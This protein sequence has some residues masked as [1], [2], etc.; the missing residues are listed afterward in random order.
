MHYI[1]EN[2]LLEEV[3]SQDRVKQLEAQLNEEITARQRLEH[4]YQ[5]RL[6][7]ARQD[8]LASQQRSQRTITG[9]NLNALLADTMT[10][11]SAKSSAELFVVQ[12]AH[13]EIPI[14]YLNRQET[15]ER[16]MAENEVLK[17]QAKDAFASLSKSQSVCLNV[18]CK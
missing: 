17:L 15:A 6:E 18:F 10:E 9:V 16:L 12:V 5:S 4:E 1:Q 8:A 3:L 7:I 14:L 11:G 2:D 13:I